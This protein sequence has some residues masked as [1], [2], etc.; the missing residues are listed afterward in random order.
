[1]Y[2][3]LLE[4][5]QG[6]GIAQILGLQRRSPD[7]GGERDQEAEAQAHLAGHPRDREVP[8]LQEIV[9]ESDCPKTESD[10]HDDPDEAVVEPRPEER[11]DQQRAEDHHAAHGRRAGLLDQVALGPVVADRLALP[12][13]PAQPVYNRPAEDEGKKQRGHERPAR[14]E[15]DVAE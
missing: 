15:G 6:D 2:H 13:H 10:Q 5:W 4:H 8:H 9:G 7:R 3:R 11:R 12:L 1:M 14:P